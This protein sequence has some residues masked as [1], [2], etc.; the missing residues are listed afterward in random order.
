MD[1][2]RLYIIFHDDIMK[3]SELLQGTYQMD[4][5]WLLQAMNKWTMIGKWPWTY[6][7]NATTMNVHLQKSM[8]QANPPFEYD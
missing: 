1:A 8:H 7:N 3:T 4:D 5:G 2:F 6:N